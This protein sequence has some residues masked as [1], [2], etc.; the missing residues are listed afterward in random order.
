MVKYCEIVVFRMLFFL[1]LILLFFSRT[2]YAENRSDDT[3]SLSRPTAACLFTSSILIG[4]G[5]AALSSGHDYSKTQTSYL[6]H[7]TSTLADIGPWVPDL[8]RV[9]LYLTGCESR[10]N[11]VRNV[12]SRVMAYVFNLGMTEGLKRA[13][14]Q[15]RPDGTDNHSTPSGHAAWAF[16]SATFLDEEYGSLSPFVTLGGYGIAT[17]VAMSRTIENHHYAGDVL[18]GA[19]I[20]LLSARAGYWLCD[21]V[22][23]GKGRRK[24]KGDDEV[25]QLKEHPS[26]I[27]IYGGYSL[28]LNEISHSGKYSISQMPA[29][30]TGVEGA[31]FPSHHIGVGGRT[32]IGRI[33]FKKDG[34]AATAWAD[35]FTALGGVYLSFPLGEKIYAGGKLLGGYSAQTGGRRVSRTLGLHPIEGGTV[36]TGAYFGFSFRKNLDLRT[37]VDY[38]AV[39]GNRTL[40]YL[41]PA[42]SLNAFF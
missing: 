33:L 8:A 11:W 41:T 39:C 29:L 38:E 4:S 7:H 13:I 16:M 12:N 19:G 25:Y 37:Q 35:R 3:L 9:T 10:S 27:G 2:L 5:I 6:P 18:L 40:H 22:F 26:F 30:Q 23:K 17:A 15:R 42:I 21:W 34:K 1:F 36:A 14:K 32:S 28:P 31:F 24:M 20:G